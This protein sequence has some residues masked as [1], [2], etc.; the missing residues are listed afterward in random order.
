VVFSINLQFFDSNNAVSVWWN[1]HIS[2]IEVPAPHLWPPERS[3]RT[4]PNGPVFSLFHKGIAIPGQKTPLSGWILQNRPPRSSIGGSRPLTGSRIGPSWSQKVVSSPPTFDLGRKESFFNQNRLKK[5]QFLTLKSQKN[6]SFITSR[7]RKI[8][9]Y[10]FYFPF[11][12][13]KGKITANFLI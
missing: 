6:S 9:T 3:P 12:I 4:P 13:K 10:P 2:G 5:R 1:P 7:K 11:L 8:M